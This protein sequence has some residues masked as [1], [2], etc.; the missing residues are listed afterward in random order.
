MHSLTI[1]RVPPAGRPTRKSPEET[2]ADSGSPDQQI[3][4]LMVN[5]RSPELV[6]RSV[7]SILRQ[8]IAQ[9]EQIVV[10]DNKSGDNS[11]E[12]IARVFPDLRIIASDA[13][14]GF[15]AGVNIGLSYVRDK[16][17]LVLNP[18]TYFENNSIFKALFYMEDHPNVGIVGLDLISKDGCSAVFSAPV[19]FPVR[20]RR[21]SYRPRRKTV[22]A[23]R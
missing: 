20:R 12:R 13:N 1:E 16:Y 8:G 11:V 9:L 3:G 23:P 15:G 19:L 18:D 7:T 14:D 10:V 6:I 2:T 21:A 22:E 17:V 5:Y 4:V